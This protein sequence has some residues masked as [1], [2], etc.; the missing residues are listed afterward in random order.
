MGHS[1]D[2][3]SQIVAAILKDLTG[4][5]GL[6]QMWESIDEDIQQE[7]QG[8]WREIVEE[9]LRLYRPEGTI[10]ASRA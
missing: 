4:R 10:D 3:A 5:G 8:T 2:C 9:N 1:A 6:R 7:I